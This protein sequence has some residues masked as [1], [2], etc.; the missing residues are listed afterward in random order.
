MATALISKLL[1]WPQIKSEDARTLHSLSLFL[2]TCCNALGDVDYMDELD[3]PANMRVVIATFFDITERK[4]SCVRFVDLVTFVDKEPRIANDPLFGELQGIAA[5]GKERKIP[6]AAKMTRKDKPRGSSFAT[7]V[8]LFSEAVNAN[9]RATTS[10]NNIA[11]TKPCLYCRKNH[12]MTECHQILEKS[13]KEKLDFSRRNG[14][15]FGCLLKGH[16][17]KDCNRRMTCQMC[18]QKHPSLLHI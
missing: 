15:C 11:L 2:V 1:N 6:V 16:L 5:E 4:Q 18:S 13:H 14:I 7:C 9:N 17:S 10:Y 3:N 12:T 8:S